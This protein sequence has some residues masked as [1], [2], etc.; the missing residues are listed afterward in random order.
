MEEIKILMKECLPTV[1]QYD[2]PNITIFYSDF[3]LVNY[4]R[5]EWL[6]KIHIRNKKR[7]KSE[8]IYK[9]IFMQMTL[10]DDLDSERLSEMLLA[11]GSPN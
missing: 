8:K 11:Y 1:Y 6:S 7:L 2:H 10:N 3:S 9:M 5:R 4:R